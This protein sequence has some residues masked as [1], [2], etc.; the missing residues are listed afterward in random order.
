MLHTARLGAPHGKPILGVNLGGFGFLSAV[1]HAGLYPFLEEMMEGRSTL[2]ARM[3][4]QAEVVMEGAPVT[5]YFA[6]NDVVIAK[7]AIAA[8]CASSPTSPASRSPICR[9]TASSSPPLPAPPAMP[10]P[11]AARWSPRTS[12]AFL[13]TP[14]CPHTLSARTLLVPAD[15]TVT[16]TL[17]E[18][19]GRKCTS[20]ATGRRACPCMAWRPSTSPKRPSPP[21][22]SAPPTTLSTRA[23]KRSSAGEGLPMRTATARRVSGLAHVDRR[24]KQLLHRLNPGEIAVISHTDLDAPCATVLVEKQAAAVI[25]AQRSLS[26]RFPHPGPGLLL[27]AHIPLIDCAG[28]DLL[29]LVTEGSMV[30]VADG[31]VYLDG[32]LIATGQVLTEALLE[33]QLEEAKRNVGV[34]MAKF[35]ENTLTYVV[36][37]QALLFENHGRPHACVPKFAGRHCLIVV[38]GP[39]AEAD[40]RAIRSY[41]YA[42]M[43]PVLVGVDGGADSCSAPG[44]RPDI[45]IGDMDSVSDATLR[46]GAELSSTPTPTARPLARKRLQPWAAPSGARLAGPAKTSPCCSAYEQGADL[47]AAVGTHFS[48]SEFLEKSRG[49]MSS[50]FLVRLKVGSI[51]VDAKGISRLFS[52]PFQS[53]RLFLYLIVVAGLTAMLL[54]ARPPPF[55][56]FWNSGSSVWPGCFIAAISSPRFG[57]SLWPSIIAIISPAS[58]RCS[59]RCC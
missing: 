25:N 49:G 1:P 38:R 40:L 3:M 53:Q 19:A 51:L 20:P 27:Q 4:L 47:I 16:V 54:L 6:L 21:T 48:L 10:S 17:R 37:E 59:W 2:Q 18:P 32:K 24:T 22:S 14:I 23:C 34:E 11:P 13:I 42:V 46:S 15:R 50:T 26:G 28:D 41:I 30:E 5:R 56:A 52:T 57:R 35:V 45:I 44:Y 31:S 33:R 36:N 39:G 29:S 8:S 12:R 9:P 43:R 7:G 58:S 55:A